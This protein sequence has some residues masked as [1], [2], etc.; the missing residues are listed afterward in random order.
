MQ[1]IQ[2]KAELLHWFR[3]IRTTFEFSEG[4]ECA[5]ESFAAP[6][7]LFCAAGSTARQL[8]QDRYREHSFILSGT[9]LDRGNRLVISG[10]GDCRVVLLEGEGKAQLVVTAASATPLL[11]KASGLDDPEE[12]QRFWKAGGMARFD[13]LLADGDELDEKQVKAAYRRWALRVHPDKQTGAECDADRRAFGLAFARLE[14]SREKLE[15]MMAEDIESCREL[16]RVLHSEVFT[17]AGAAA[18]LG[19][20][21]AAANTDSIVEE[22]AKEAEKAAKELKKKI[23]KMEAVAPDFRQAEAICDEAVRTLARAT[24]AEALPR[25]EALLR[26]GASCSRALGLRDL[27]FPRPVVLMEPKSIAYMLSTNASVRFALLCGAT[28]AISD[29]ELTRAAAAHSRRPK[30]SV[31]VFNALADAQPTSSNASSASV[32]ISVRRSGKAETS[33]AKRQKTG[34]SDTVRVRHILLRHQQVRQ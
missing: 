27:R 3:C 24:T 16:R 10:V 25:N 13:V 30:A 6:R 29:E 8:E 7:W 17:R 15:A 32:C 1:P 21:K 4:S 22:V 26:E 20:D 2:C 12:M 18:L 34:S 11:E 33:A 28:A 31:L 19:V 5:D 14:E 23:A 9:F